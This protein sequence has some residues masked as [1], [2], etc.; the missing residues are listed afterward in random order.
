MR[1]V[2]KQGQPKAPRFLKG[3]GTKPTTVTWPI[4]TLLTRP[5]DLH[6]RWAWAGTYYS[7]V[8]RGVLFWILGGG[9]PPGSS[10]SDPTSH[11][12]RNVIFLH[13]FSGLASEGYNWFTK[14][15]PCP[16]E[17]N[18][19]IKFFWSSFQVFDTEH[20]CR[21]KCFD[22]LSWFPWK[23]CPTSAHLYPF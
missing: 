21:Q 16:S 8:S 2:S 14:S 22:T 20:C 3:K 15:L 13:S 18:K 7:E 17:V 12:A 10:N 23:Q 19:L 5:H 4:F 11:G 9:L 6:W 1:F